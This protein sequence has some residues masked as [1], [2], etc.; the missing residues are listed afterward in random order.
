M[1]PYLMNSLATSFL[2]R[3]GHNQ[4]SG[5]SLPPL[6]PLWVIEGGEKRRR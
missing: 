5:D 6:S 4:H 2:S 3:C 1:S